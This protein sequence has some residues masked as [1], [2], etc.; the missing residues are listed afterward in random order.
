MC[1]RCTCCAVGVGSYNPP[2]PSQGKILFMH[3]VPVASSLTREPSADPAG[4]EEAWNCLGG[5]GESGEHAKALDGLATF[6]GRVK[7]V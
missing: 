3:F 5:C 4:P 7:K 2:L 6:I 1:P